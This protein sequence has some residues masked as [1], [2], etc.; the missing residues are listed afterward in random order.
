M[1]TDSRTRM[2]DAATQ[3]FRVQ[4]VH[5]TGLAEVL[6]KSG[7][8]RGSL[9]H[10][11]PGGKE[12]LTVETIERAAAEIHAALDDLFLLDPPAALREY[13]ARVAARLRASD[14]ADGCPVGNPAVEASVSSSA[15]RI[16]C[17]NAFRGWE[18]MITERLEREGIAREEAAHLATFI[19]ATSEGALLVA[20]ARRDT[21]PIEEA[22]ELLAQ[23][24][25]RALGRL[26]V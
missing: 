19:V 2:L 22:C 12:Q 16:A 10:Y 5:A 21:A 4:G 18:T 25:E 14:Y 23:T 9:Y 11:F 8:P 26:P 17:D 7:A 24:V 3:L 6:E 1:T 13:G 20:R 15:I